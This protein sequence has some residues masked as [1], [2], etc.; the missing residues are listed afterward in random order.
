MDVEDV[1]LYHRLDSVE[2]L[3]T[4]LKEMVILNYEGCEQDVGFAKFFVLNAVVLKK[5]KFGVHKN[6][7]GDWVAIQLDLLQVENRTSQDAQ[8]DFKCGLDN[9]I[10]Y[11]RIHDLSLTDPFDC[12]LSE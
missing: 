8:F 11:P 12:L 1:P 5:I 2:C 7:N 9:V 6:N 4:H 10:N 3:G